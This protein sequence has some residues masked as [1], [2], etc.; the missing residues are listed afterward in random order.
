[1]LLNQW[2][3]HSCESD[4]LRSRRHLPMLARRG[5]AH[6]EARQAYRPDSVG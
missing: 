4:A 2:V 1:M 6:E 5:V 3:A